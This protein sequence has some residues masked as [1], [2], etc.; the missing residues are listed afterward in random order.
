MSIGLHHNDASKLALSC[1]SVCFKTKRRFLML[2]DK[3]MYVWENIIYGIKKIND[4]GWQELC[5]AP[6]IAL[7]PWFIHNTVRRLVPYCLHFTFMHL[8]DAFI[9][10][11]LQCIQAIHLYCQYVCSLGIEPTTFALL[12]QRSKHWATGILFIAYLLSS[13]LSPFLV[14]GI[15]R[16]LVHLSSRWMLHTGS[17]LRRDPAPPLPPSS[18]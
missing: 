17:W 14:K 10:S 7:Q 8:A 18:L 11:D 4:S 5:F 9:Q 16:P 13:L 2:R 6:N 3:M 12:T 1:E 15:N